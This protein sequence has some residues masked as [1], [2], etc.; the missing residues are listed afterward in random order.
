LLYSAAS[1]IDRSRIAQTVTP[2]R[3]LNF[4]VVIP[5]HNEAA[6]VRAVA[7]GALRHAS[8]VIVVDDGSAD[9]TAAALEGL[10][11][12]LLV[13]SANEG[14]AA[15]LWRG[16]QHAL[17][18]EVEAVMTLDGDG[19]HDPADVPRLVTAF[20]RSPEKI[21]IGAR[22][23]DRRNIPALRYFA[24]RFA[25]FWIA[26]AAGY[27]IEDS[28]SG[29]RLYPA[30]LLKS[31][32]VAHD[33]RASF[34]FESEILIEASR[35]GVGSVAVRVAAQYPRS[36]R[37]SHFRPVLDVLRI[38]RMVAR[39]LLSRGLHLRGLLRSLKSRPREPREER[40]GGWYKS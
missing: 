9:G 28:Q 13:N 24:N 12:A 33:P 23:A 29:F 25:N 16:M 17:A 6:T 10:P 40:D 19:Q 8:L 4:A 34:V 5:A 20:R 38:T 35:L 3:E 1:S 18:C 21:V 36:G 27:P 31:V 37:R 7:L 32:R 11:V 14:K 30:P 39:K 2:P 15:S 22:L 26:W